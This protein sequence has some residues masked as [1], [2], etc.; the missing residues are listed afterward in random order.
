MAPITGLLVAL[1]SAGAPSAAGEDAF[2]CGP[3]EVQGV[4]ATDA[5][6]AVGLVC[7]QIIRESDGR[8]RYVVSLGTLGRVVILV[9]E[10]LDE[11]R[12][13]T[14]RLEGIEETGVAAPR[15][16]RAIVRGEPFPATQRVDNLLEGEVRP[17]LTK[18]GSVKFAAGVADVETPGHGARGTG[19][20][21]GLQ[22]ATPRFALPVDLRL[23]K[24]DAEYGEAQVDLFSISVGGRGF[25]STRN[26]SPFLGGGLGM[27]WLHA[28]EGTDP[29][30]GEAS[31]WFEADTLRVAPYVEA[32][33]EALRLHRGRVALFVR[34]DLPLSPLRSPEIRYSDWDPR[35]GAPGEQVVLPGSARYV[36]PVSI[37]LTVA[38]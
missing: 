15:V 20:Q 4:A 35:T 23:A 21:L 7:A 16:A 29:Y 9:V 12:S 2:A 18:R 17:A 22:Y 26:V 5:A 11:S 8:G 14:V 30:S 32:G 27:I 38:F 25:L 31:T 3:K 37:G 36:A 13:V 19:F 10:R 1:L 6:T 24:G 34:A 28:S 33:V